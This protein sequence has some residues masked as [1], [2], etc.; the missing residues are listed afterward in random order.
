M[1]K[2]Q[3][4]KIEILFEIIDKH[5]QMITNE[6]TK[7]FNISVMD[8]L[9]EELIQE[10]G[11]GYNLITDFNIKILETPLEQIRQFVF[12]TEIELVADNQFRILYITTDLPY[13]KLQYL[14]ILFYNLYSEG[15]DYLKSLD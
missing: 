1:L 9:Y 11:K 13:Y 10:I 14:V 5:L 2:M 8:S 15:N 7:N 3:N 12:N 4:K 6:K